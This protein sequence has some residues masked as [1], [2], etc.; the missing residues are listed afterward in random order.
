MPSRIILCAMGT[1]RGLESLRALLADQSAGL[2]GASILLLSLI[3]IFLLGDELPAGRDHAAHGR[4][5]KERV[6]LHTDVVRQEERGAAAR[7]P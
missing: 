5:D 7:R 6:N 2:F 1:G 4:D 3:H